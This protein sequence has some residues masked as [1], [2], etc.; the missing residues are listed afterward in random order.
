MS[1]VTVNGVQIY[2]E[3]SGRGEIPVVL[4]H[5]SWAS[6]HTWDAFVPLLEAS[7]R[8][9]IYDRRGH[10]RSER[11]SGQGSIREDVA[12]LAALIDHFELAPAWVVGNS[13]GGLIALRLAG[14]RP[15]LLRG[16]SGHEPP[17]FSL[18]EDVPSA[19]PALAEVRALDAA[20]AERASGGDYAAAAEHFIESIVG[21]DAWGQLPDAYRQ[22]LVDNAPTYLDE[23]RD[24]E[25]EFFDPK[26][27]AEFAGP[28][29]LTR[30]QGLDVLVDPMYERV[31][32]LLP[33]VRFQ[34]IREGGHVPQ[35]YAPEAYAEALQRFIG[36]G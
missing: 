15:Q 34:T 12:D 19:A 1:R 3:L 9:L 36:A 23:I 5:G 2:Y 35:R 14:E 13:Q 26:W 20:V 29:L 18:I 21:P 31:A 27:I 32:E 11:P 6:H 4:I 28:V 10:S 24:P 22:E 8:I 16:L 30:G 17:L 25:N 33:A 7:Y